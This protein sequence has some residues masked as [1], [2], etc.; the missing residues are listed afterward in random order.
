MLKN[1]LLPYRELVLEVAD[2]LIG[3]VIVFEL[4]VV[5]LL[6]FSC[7]VYTVVVL[8][9]NSL[10]IVVRKE[11]LIFVRDDDTQVNHLHLVN[12]DGKH[13]DE[14]SELQ[15]IVILFALVISGVEVAQG[16]FFEVVEG[17]LK[18]L[19]NAY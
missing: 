3:D 9:F 2:L 18:S 6:G 12:S 19:I 13:V 16:D 15:L 17:S 10:L 5:V 4:A 14:N 11:H 1:F 7:V 8:V